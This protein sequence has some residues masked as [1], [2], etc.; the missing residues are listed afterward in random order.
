VTRDNIVIVFQARELP[1]SPSTN[2]RI[3]N[4]LEAAYPQ[5]LWPSQ[6]VAGE[7]LGY[8]Y[9]YYAT[10]NAYVGIK[11]GHDDY[12]VPAIDANIH[13]L[14]AAADWLGVAQGAGY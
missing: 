9:R 8:Q 12:L 7:A 1:A 4:Y 11:D 3:F 5:Y 13:T 6:G 14:G 10:S 2:D